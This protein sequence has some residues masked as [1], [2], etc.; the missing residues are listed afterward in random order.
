MYRWS[1]QGMGLGNNRSKK[2]T[3]LAAIAAGGWDRFLVT[4]LCALYVTLPA[5]IVQV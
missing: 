5:G 4:S 1:V 3:G 2:E